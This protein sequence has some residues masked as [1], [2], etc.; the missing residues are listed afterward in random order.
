MLIVKAQS[1][2]I[3]DL[4]QLSIT[5]LTPHA[6]ILVTAESVDMNGRKWQSYA[7][8]RATE[9]G[10]VDLSEQVPISGTYYEADAMGLFWS[11]RPLPSAKLDTTFVPSDKS[12]YSVELK[13]YQANK[14]ILT[15]QLVR[16]FAAKS[17]TSEMVHQ[18]NFVG[19]L[20]C[21]AGEGPFPGIVLCGGSE[22]GISPQ[23]VHATVLASHGYLVLI[24]AYYKYRDLPQEFYDVPLDPIVHAI[25]WLNK[26]PKVID[27][28]IALMGFSKG[29]EA[30][31]GSAVAT[32]DKS[33]AA[34]ITVSPSMI[35]WQ[36]FGS[37]SAKKRPSWQFRGKA[38]PFAK[39]NVWRIVPQ[40]LFHR[41]IRKLNLTKRLQ[42]HLPLKLLPMYN[43][44]RNKIRKY[45]Q[46][47]IPVNEI[48][49]P[50]CLIAGGKDLVWPAAQMTET[51]QLWRR[52]CGFDHD[53][54]QI[55]P[56]A[57]HVF[58]LPYLPTTVPWYLSEKGDYGIKFGGAARANAHAALSA[59]QHIISFLDKHL[60]NS[61]TPSSE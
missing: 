22:G 48:Y 61:N 9:K 2:L 5:E 46:A 31:L 36:G 4:M 38:A 20:Y 43:N 40:I 24:V 13:V 27:N 35:L 10:I 30:I 60:H 32:K 50:L 3:T 25:P 53:Q 28:K 26:H 15:H 54:V 42:S 17:V 51:I 34:V 19:K 39:Y 6:N 59:W 37:E 49:A 45:H 58:A 1:D 8:F 57:G 41:L 44:L 11:M 16:R 7:H 47:I 21:P 55:Y 23:E 14:L 12:R 33:L 18:D 52:Q 56:Q 29:A